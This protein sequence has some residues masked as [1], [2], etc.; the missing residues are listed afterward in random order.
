MELAAGK[1]Q[2]V[3]FN[4]KKFT[5]AA[6]HIFNSGK[7]TAD[8]ITDKPVKELISETNRAIDH[9]VK[10]GIADNKPSAK[11][12]DKLDNDVFVFSTC[13]THIQLKEVGA[14]LTSEDTITPWS[15][16]R[17]KVLEIHKLYNEDYLQAEYGFA[18]SSAEMGAKWDRWEQEGDRY[19][20][21]YRTAQD[22][23]VRVSHAELAG[24][25]LPVSDP[26]WNDYLPPNGWNCRCTTVQVN[27]GKYPESNSKS[28]QDKG[29]RAT[30]EIDSKGHNR[31]AM[32]R[33]NP[34]KQKVIF[35]PHHPYYKVWKSIENKID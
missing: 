7:Y 35:P 30:T 25:T 22:D 26:F 20:L 9:A 19:N 11:T 10:K 5:N 16:F 18:V 32:F 24:I 17:T 33:F 21:Q 28:S 12:L 13:K 1:K 31:S 34:G 4:K 6:R 3:P 23:R 15:E 29:E 8:M 2:A 27:T 14:M